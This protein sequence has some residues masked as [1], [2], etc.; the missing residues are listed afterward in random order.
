[1]PLAFK[2][3]RPCSGVSCLIALV[4]IFLCVG[5]MSTCNSLY[6]VLAILYVCFCYISTCWLGTYSLRYYVLL[7]FPFIGVHFA[8]SGN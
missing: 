4:F 7:R 2:I 1:V 6:V 8:V 3:G 5:L